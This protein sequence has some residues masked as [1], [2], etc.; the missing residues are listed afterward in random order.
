MRK[1]HLSKKIAIFLGLFLT[2]QI[3]PL[4]SEE[5]LHPD[6]SHRISGPVI[7]KI[8][9]QY[10]YNHRNVD[11][12]ISSETLDLF[13]DGLDRNKM[14]FLSADIAS[15]EKYRT[16]LDD[17]LLSGDFEAPFHIFGLLQQRLNERIE[18]IM[19]R[20][21][22]NFDFSIDED[23]KPNRS[24]EN[25]A[26]TPEE[27]DELWRKRLKSEALNLKL[28]GKAWEDIQST[29]KK[30][31]SNV[32]KNINKYNSED[33][34][35]NFMN[36]FSETYDPHTGYFSPIN[37]E[38]F[39]IDMSLSF[40]GIGAQLNTEDDYTNVVR[41]LPGGPAERSK[42]LRANDKIVGVAQGENGEM[43]DVIG[44][45]LDD[46]VQKIRGKRGSQVR[47][48]IIPANS[49]IGSPTKEIILTRDKIVL[50]ERAAR[51]DTAE[52]EHDGESY[53]LGV[54]TIPSFYIDLDAQRRGDKNY[55]STTRDVRRLLNELSGAD[56][57]GII[58]DLRRNGGG[59]L[60]E[61][62]ELTGLFIEEGPVVQVKD[63]RGKKGVEYDPDPDIL[64][65]GP[66]AVMVNRL[67]ASASEIFSS[68]IQ[69]YG[70]GVVIG[71]QTFGKGTVQRLLSLDRFIKSE[72][73]KFGQ[74]KV[75]TAKF[76][77]VTGGT[78]QHRGVLPD[79]NFP[80]IYNEWDNFG[81]D[82]E[83]YALPWD[84]ISPAM[85]KT[86]DRV[87]QYLAP[88][89][90]KSK[91]RTEKDAEFQYLREDIERYKT[92]SK[93]VSLQEAKRKAK[94]KAAEKVTLTRVN[95]RRKLAGKELIADNESIPAD[96]QVPDAR[97][98]ESQRILA[99]LIALSGT[100]STT[101]V[102]TGDKKHLRTPGKTETVK[103]KEG[104]N[105]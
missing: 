96:E 95:E 45:R 53:R 63:L 104:K 11:D 26:S 98:L 44:W 59:S 52:F 94:R 80:S 62:I 73:E 92:D 90:L 40:E 35:Q 36:A 1:D 100:K 91:K 85:Y 34:F 69:D 102:K 86:D 17:E 48:E 71:S 8:L 21:E 64:Y 13:I 39:G 79:I 61:A 74:L 5:N 57:D 49:S 76:Y 105:N 32:Q 18:Y 12:T 99:D 24:E 42:K 4:A 30:R 65:D 78:T 97:L 66:L 33:V 38:N 87:S 50:E 19:N 20:L 88:L 68:A 37:S 2:L 55:K 70:R 101:V 46:V 47:L 41:I 28:A 75:T 56:V 81:E 22:T 89:R 84:E 103:R 83:I 27:L 43:I 3:S 15:F 6:K 82:N 9:K 14:Y 31:Y 23:Y 67:S 93:L 60:Q 25:W 72:T 29:L 58:I 54:I 7:A 51:S 16:A 77:R 10:H